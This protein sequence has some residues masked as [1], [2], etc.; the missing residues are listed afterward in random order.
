MMK[1]LASIVLAL[2][3]ANVASA[4]IVTLVPIDEGAPGSATNPL[5]DSDYIEILINVDPKV[6][7]V[8]ALVE[9]AGPA[10]VTGAVNLSDCANYGWDTSLSFDPI[11]TTTTADIGVGDFAGG[12]DT[13]TIGGYITLHCTGAGPVT[14]TLMGNQTFGGSYDL[15]GSPI[16]G[17]EITGTLTIH[18]IP[19]PATLALLGLGGLLLR[20]RK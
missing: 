14:V 12:P 13:D 20:R 6:M 8:D 16:P 1:K 11:L 4:A 9:V 17:S 10:Q 5:K 3:F 2:L 19:E 15:S 18:Q 7:S